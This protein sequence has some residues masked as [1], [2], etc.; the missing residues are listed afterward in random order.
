MWVP[1]TKLGSQPQAHL[2][3]HQQERKVTDE[4]KWLWNNE[5]RVVSY[6]IMV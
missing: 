1:G 3:V 6:L 2:S 4:A 5:E